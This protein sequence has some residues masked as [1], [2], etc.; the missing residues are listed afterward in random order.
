MASFW[1]RVI[2]TTLAVLFLLAVGF[3]S[4]FPGNDPYRCRAIQSTGRWIDPPDEEGNRYPFNQWQ[5]DGCIMNKYESEDIRRCMQGRRIVVVGDSTSR[6]VGHGISRLLDTERSNRDR[7]ELKMPKSQFFNMTYYGQMI[8]RLPNIF[9]EWKDNASQ[10]QFG[11]N[12]RMY[13]NEKQNTPSVEEQEAPALIYMAGGV[14][15]TRMNASLPGGTTVISP[16]STF[17]LTASPFMLEMLNSPWDNRFGTYKEYMSS[18]FD[19]ITDNTP[20]IDPFSAPMDPIDGLGNQMFYGPPAGPV[21]LGDDPVHI[22]D[23]HRR[24]GETTMMRDWLHQVEQD[25]NLPIIWS[26]PMLTYCQNKTW[27]DGYKTGLHVKHGIADTR[28]NII[29]NL[30]CNA[31]LDR[32]KS[33]PYK[34]TCCTDY[35]VKPVTQLGIV[36]LGI[37]YLAACLVGE[38]LDLYHDRNEPRWRFFTMRAGSFVLALLMCYYADRTQMMAK[39]EKL[40]Q[41]INFA[42]L[43]APCLVILLLTIRRSRSPIPMGM[44][45]SL[46]T[47]ETNEPFL[48]RQQTEEWKGWM[49]ALILIYHWTGAIKGSKSIYILIRLCVAAYLFQ[50]GYGHTLYFLRK[51]DFSFCRVA[52]VL[53]RLNLLSCCLA[54]VM[55]TDYMFYYFAPLVSFWFLVVYGTMA[56]GGKRYN[57]DPQVVLSK[58]CISGLLVS[59]IFMGTPLTKFVFNL[60][61]TLFNIQWSYKEWQYRVTLDMFIV[62]VGMLTAVVNNEMEKTV[63]HLGLRIILAVAGL[64]GTMY[65]FNATLHLRTKVYKAWHP[66]IS[67][68]PIL[69]FIALRNICAPVRNYH[70]TAM[71]W[72]GRC[73]LETY[74]LQYHL[75]MAADTEAVLIVDGLFGDGTVM[76]DRWRTLV[77]VVPVFLWL[78]NSVAKSTA[79]IVDL[80]ME[81]SEEDEKTSSSSFAWLEKVPGYGWITAPKVR[82]ACILLAMWILNMLTPGHGEVPAPSGG[83]HVTSAPLPPW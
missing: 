80:I 46:S 29:L 81:S 59:A 25:W 10:E 48:S 34:R 55:D 64:F 51:N 45:I 69:A 33:Y 19:F 71:A 14:W 7:K 36:A 28:A 16:N 43:C 44:E 11:Q 20:D 75:L 37:I 73:S 56:V 65:Y 79:Y 42:I 23:A 15:F 39:G 49:Q 67:F 58:I 74:I 12:L 47:N 61:Q 3:K 78:S 6:N 1:A 31:K 52:A 53:L 70:S 76:G 60:L 2:S 50:T 4:L 17:A 9:L 35:G 57:S 82:V 38:M 22:I 63:V 27:L 62:Y 77:I 72:L 21:Y 68:I 26:I 41:P 54:Y 83:H 30:R 13:A 32:L 24:S 40:W 8:Q 18:I 66:L 5:P